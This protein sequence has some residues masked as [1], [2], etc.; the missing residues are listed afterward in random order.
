M[1]AESAGSTE[2]KP[3]IKIK[4]GGKDVGTARK[5]V[6]GPPKL[7]IRLP[8]AKPEPVVEPIKVE[9][10]KKAAQEKP[11]KRARKRKAPSPDEVI[12]VSRQSKYLFVEQDC[13][14]SCTVY[15]YF[16]GAA[17]CL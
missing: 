4:L 16:Y 9:E 6:D 2:D 1:K 12:P 8:S 10:S 11:A 13:P 14:S 3:S 17:L 5:D 15:F 7:K